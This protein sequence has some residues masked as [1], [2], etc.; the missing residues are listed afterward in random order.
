[1]LT[2]NEVGAFIFD[3]LKNDVTAEELASAI[4]EEYKVDFETAL[5]DVNTFI[6]KLRQKDIIDD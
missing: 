4:C 6:E 2:L 3:R 1:M 5:K